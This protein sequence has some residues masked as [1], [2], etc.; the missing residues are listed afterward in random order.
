MNGD[1][2]VVIILILSLQGLF[3]DVVSLMKLPV[4]VD[5]RHTVEKLLPYSYRSIT[6][7]VLITLP[8]WLSRCHP[9]F[10]TNLK[11]ININFSPYFEKLLII[12]TSQQK[13]YR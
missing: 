5:Y 7:F 6:T 11:I 9:T 1:Y 2:E 10:N 12:F 3:D 13:H 8:E 4:D